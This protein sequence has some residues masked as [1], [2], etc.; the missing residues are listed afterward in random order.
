MSVLKLASLAT[1]SSFSILSSSDESFDSSKRAACHIEGNGIS[2]DFE[3]YTERYVGYTYILGRVYNLRKLHRHDVQIIENSPE[4]GSVQVFDP[5]GKKDSW[6]WD[7][8]RKLGNIGSLATDEYGKGRYEL[9]NK[10]I[11]L[12]GP[13]SVVNK[14]IAVFENTLDY[15]DT[16]EGQQVLVGRGKVLASGVILP[17]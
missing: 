12:E 9:V 2:G 5:E 10:A 11:R 17:I 7:P 14:K 16:V 15:K 1:L 13:L 8:E 4:A 3:F 6:P